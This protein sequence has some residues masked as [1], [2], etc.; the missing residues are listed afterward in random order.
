MIILK[1]SNKALWAL[2]AAF[3]AAFLCTALLPRLAS[4]QPQFAGFRRG[5]DALAAG[6]SEKPDLLISLLTRDEAEWLE[7]WLNSTA[8]AMRINYSIIVS[9]TPKLF[10]AHKRAADASDARGRVFFS[11]PFEKE[12]VGRDL[13]LAHVRNLREAAR[14]APFFSH[15]TLL[16]SNALW[17]RAVDAPTLSRHLYGNGRAQHSALSDWAWADAVRQDE[18]ICRWANRLHMGIQVGQVEGWAAARL[19][20]D[21]ALPELE[22]ALQCNKLNN[23][24]LEELAFSSVTAHLQSGALSAGFSRIGAVAWWHPDM[25][26]SDDEV[27]KFKADDRGPLFIKRVPRN[28]SD[29]YTHKVALW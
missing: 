15:A 10:Q 27:A 12:T 11:Q 23:Y 7:F 19:A 16:A 8:R 22:R 21:A 9:S 3:V 6:A 24:P 18:C 14:A 17:I 5:G 2:G 20:I 13:L 25:H 26:F 28:A 29:P 1:E 4:P